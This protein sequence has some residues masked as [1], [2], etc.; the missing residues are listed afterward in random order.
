M[1]KKQIILLSVIVL[2][3]FILRLY[4]IRNPI[5][6]WHSWRQADTSA[7]SRSFVQKGFD[8]LHPRFND[9][10]NIP[11]GKDNPEGY[12]FVEF[13]SYN[14]V[15]AFLAKNLSFFSLEIWGRLISNIF[16]CFSLIFLFFIVKDLIDFPMALLA[17]FFFAVLPFNIYYSRVI[18]PEPMMIMTMLGAIYFFLRFI[19]KNSKIYLGNF[20]IFTAIS[21]LIKP[22][23]LFIIAP[24][25]FYLLW[26]QKGLTR[27]LFFTGT[28]LLISIVPFL[29]WRWWINHF[30]EGIPANM[31]LL[32]AGGMRLKPA[33]FRWLFAERLSKLILGYWGIVIFILGIIAKTEKKEGRFF[34]FWLLGTLVYLIVVARGNIQHDYYQILLVPVICVF[35]G[36]GAKVILAPIKEFRKVFSKLFLFIC[37]VF[38]WAFSWYQVRDFFNINNFKMITA[39]RRADEILPKEAKVIAPLGGDTAFLYQINRDGWPQGIEIDKLISKGATHYVNFDFGPETEYIEQK[40]CVLEKTDDY[41]IAKLVDCQK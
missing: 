23:T 8:I 24:S 32:N 29:W 5:A 1:N 27:S 6:D 4:R 36:K 35:L 40:F 17:S 10:S 19:R 9:L 28:Y 22:F 25:I 3:N 33:W 37:F 30:P 38:M 26:R 20:L 34:D 16:S 41:I 31:W 14:I 21:I 18:L 7:V 39:G 11:S 2:I 12:R 15:H 13:P